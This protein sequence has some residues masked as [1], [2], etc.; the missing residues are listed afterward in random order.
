M[1]NVNTVFTMRKTERERV[2]FND[3]D[4]RFPKFTCHPRCRSD[5]RVKTFFGGE[6]DEQANDPFPGVDSK[7]KDPADSTECLSLSQG[8]DLAEECHKMTFAEPTVPT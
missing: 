3:V 6:G 2:T 5:I 1:F 4:S 7:S 8:A